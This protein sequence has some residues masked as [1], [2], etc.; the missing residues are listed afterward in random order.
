MGF[1]VFFYQLLISTDNEHNLMMNDIWGI[2]LL[3]LQLTIDSLFFH[4]L[5]FM[6]YKTHSSKL[7]MSKKW[8][9]CFWSAGFFF[10]FYQ[11][12]RS[13]VQNWWAVTSRKIM[14]KTSSL[15]TLNWRRRR[16]LSFVIDDIFFSP[17][18]ISLAQL[19]SCALTLVGYLLNWFFTPWIVILL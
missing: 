4:Y 17:N 10:F 15:A 1:F 8:W 16:R 7:I 6:K 5:I 14:T 9:F 19:L 3:L 18:N 13:T 11:I 12:L 2:T